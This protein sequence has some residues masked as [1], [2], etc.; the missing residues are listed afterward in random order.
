[1]GSIATD[2]VR[3]ICSR[4]AVGSGVG[5]AQ[6]GF[7]F[8]LG[9]GGT[10]ALNA[11]LAV[12][13]TFYDA[14]VP[15]IAGGAD[16]SIG[17]AVYDYSTDPPTYVPATPLSSHPTGAQP[18]LPAQCCSLISWRSGTAGPTG[19]GRTYIGPLS[20]VAADSNGF[21]TSTA[22]TAMNTAGGKITA[23][24]SSAS[25][26]SMFLILSR[27]LNKVERPTP[28]GHMITSFKFNS[29]IVTQRRRSS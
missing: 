12:L 7:W 25:D 1:M 17:S 5:V 18:L 14:M 20:A 29:R 13:K 4:N 8:L 28:V 26:G 19:R 9:S 27:F 11:A 22:T 2:T 16:Y 21:L 15:Q 3:I 6:N 24:N 23:Y 10:T